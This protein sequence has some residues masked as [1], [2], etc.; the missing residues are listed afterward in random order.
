[1]TYIS[2]DDPPL[3]RVTAR[4]SMWC[5]DK[6]LLGKNVL[7]STTSTNAALPHHCDD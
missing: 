4:T 3:M 6:H 5:R 2:M 7:S 1:M